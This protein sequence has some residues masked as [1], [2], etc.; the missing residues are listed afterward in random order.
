M[1]QNVFSININ[2]KYITQNIYKIDI[3]L[4]VTGQQHHPRLINIQSN[5]YRRSLIVLLVI[6]TIINKYYN[7]NPLFLEYFDRK[8]SAT[9]LII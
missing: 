9:I 4:Y 6:S 7:Y 2:K 1:Y 5:N 8:I 3:K